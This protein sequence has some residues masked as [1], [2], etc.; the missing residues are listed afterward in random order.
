MAD[1]S[2]SEAI[3]TG[4]G[5]VVRKPLAVLLWGVLPALVFIPLL[6]AFGGTILGVFVAVAHAGSDREAAAQAI[7]PAI[8]GILLFAL[9]TV[10][11]AWVIGAMTTAAGFR[12]VLHPEQS[13]FGYLRF[14]SRELTLMLVSLVL[15]LVFFGVGI[16]VAIPMSIIQLS[17][18]GSSTEVRTAVTILVQVA[19][20]LVTLWLYLRLCLALPMAFAE[21]RF[22][23]FES[24]DLTRGHTLKL[25]GWAV[26]AFLILAAVEIVA[27]AAG[28]GGLFGFAGGAIATLK[29]GDPSTLAPRIAAMLGAFVPVIV[30][31]SVLAVIVA[32]VSNAIMRA[33]LA[34]IYRSLVGTDV[35][36]TFT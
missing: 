34:Q 13:A 23:L 17:T 12:A 16:V 22:R 8:G 9:V 14:G 3:G 32:G 11:A 26:L 2:I 5:L 29:G 33:P 25:L 7:L 20:N 30:L 21:G 36:A 24:W 6:V 15:G 4:V 18:M 27:C 28:F 1:F 10:I 19:R 31:W 35:A